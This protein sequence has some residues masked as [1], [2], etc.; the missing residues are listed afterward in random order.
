MNS[1]DRPSQPGGNPAALFVKRT[2]R[3]VKQNERSNK[4]RGQTKREVKQNETLNQF[5]VSVSPYRSKWLGWG[6]AWLPSGRSG[7]YVL[8]EVSGEDDALGVGI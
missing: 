4:T 6:R 3:L 5:G 2:A 8:G 1:S 7:R